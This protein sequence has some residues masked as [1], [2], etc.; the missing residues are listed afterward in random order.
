MKVA[1]LSAQRNGRLYLQEIFLVLISVTGFT[2]YTTYN[3]LVL[4]SQKTPISPLG[5]RSVNVAEANSLFALR[6]IIGKTKCRA[7]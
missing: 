1:R 3:T 6:I 5:I 2:T 7:V 4:T